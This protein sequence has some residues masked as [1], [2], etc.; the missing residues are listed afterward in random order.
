MGGGHRDAEDGVGAELA[1]VLRAIEA[2][3]RGVDADLV[4]R[5][6]T[7]EEGGDLF[8]HV[9]DGLEDALAVVALL[10][11]DALSEGLRAHVA[12]AEFVGFV[13]ASR[14]AGRDGRATAD[15]GGEDD[16]DFDGGVTAGVEDL[17]G[18]DINDLGAA[19]DGK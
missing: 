5:V 6:M 7:D 14:G 19:H 12:V 15:A 13:G 9:L 10:R 17:A 4:L 8:V 16:I 2:D 11:V 18:F 1:L 3:H